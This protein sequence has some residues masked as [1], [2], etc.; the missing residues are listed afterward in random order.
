MR[1]AVKSFLAVWLISCLLGCGGKD[2]VRPSPQDFRLGQTTYA[3]VIQRMG[4]PGKTGDALKNGKTVRFI[5]YVY[6]SKGGEPLEADVIPARALAYF[7]YND[8]LVGEGFNSSFKSDNSNFDDKRVESIKKGLTTRAEV[9]KLLGEPTAK[10]ISPMVKETSG[11]AIG[12]GY[13]AVRGGLFSGLKN[14]VK[15][16][17]ISFDDRGLVSDI[18]YTSSDS[19]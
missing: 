19:K 10:F 7:F 15:V 3:Q 13:Q 2:F 9:I 8:T 14:S 17:R 12:Y 5:T 11:E 1:M 18:E 16:L 4:E 6:A